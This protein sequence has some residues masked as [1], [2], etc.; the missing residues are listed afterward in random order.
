MSKSFWQMGAQSVVS[1]G[2]GRGRLPQRRA[3]AS[4]GHLLFC[5]KGDS[6]MPLRKPGVQAGLLPGMQLHE[7]KDSSPAGGSPRPLA[8]IPSPGLWCC[9]EDGLGC[10]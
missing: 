10:L 2:V 1:W 7:S 8:V 5:M 4:P 9:L 3:R 6:L